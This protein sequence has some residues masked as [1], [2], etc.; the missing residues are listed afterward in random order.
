MLLLKN[1]CTKLKSKEHL[2]ETMTARAWGERIAGMKALVSSRWRGDSLL[3]IEMRAARAMAE[4]SCSSA[5]VTIFC[6][7]KIS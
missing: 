6:C 5:V 4:A 3:G 1:E 2:K 7:G